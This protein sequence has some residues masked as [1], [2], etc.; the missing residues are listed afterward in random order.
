MNS[1]IEELIRERQKCIDN[2]YYFATKYFKIKSSINGEMIRFSPII[3]EDKFNE[4]VNRL[5]KLNI[6]K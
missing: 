3:S 1:E 4:L 2:P 5:T 6:R